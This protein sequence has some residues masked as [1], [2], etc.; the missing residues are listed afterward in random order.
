MIY[1]RLTRFLKINVK[2][3]EYSLRLTVGMFEEIED[4][5]PKGTTLMS[6][7]MNQETPKI[8]VLKKAFCIGMIK[9]GKVVKSNE[10]IQVFNDFCDENGIQEA[11][12][13]F[14][15]LLAASHLLGAN[16]S[17]EMME[18]MGLIVK[19]PEEPEKNA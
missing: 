7:F 3:V 1:D 18:S 17:N 11:V 2:G 8:K 14:Y 19:D 13:V 4:V 12:N 5:L 9:D 10:A 6:M 15:A 16:L